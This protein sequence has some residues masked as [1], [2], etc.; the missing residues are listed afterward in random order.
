MPTR[1]L[2][3]ALAMLGS[4]GLVAACE[5]KSELE[6]AADKVE[7]AADDAADAARDATDGR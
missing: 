1:S 3:L 7:D 4:T 5:E 6:K 2:W